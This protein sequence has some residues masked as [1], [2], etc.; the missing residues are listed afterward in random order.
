MCCITLVQKWLVGDIPFI[1]IALAEELLTH[2]MTYIGTGPKNKQDIPQSMRQKTDELS[3]IFEF[4]GNKTLASH[5]PKEGKSVILPSKMH[6]T[7]PKRVR[8]KY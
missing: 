1:S 5:A 3:L 8:N 7:R 2:G 6:M 4:D